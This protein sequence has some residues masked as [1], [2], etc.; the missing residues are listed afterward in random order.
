V[1]DVTDQPVHQY[2]VRPS[3]EVEGLWAL[4]ETGTDGTE[5]E[6]FQASYKAVMAE[7]AQRRQYYAAEHRSRRKRER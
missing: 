3:R 5:R 7:R 6:V 2:T 1:P 4:V